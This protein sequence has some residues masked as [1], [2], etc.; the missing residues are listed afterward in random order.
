MGSVTEL[1]LACAGAVLGLGAWFLTWGVL[2]RRLLWIPGGWEPTT[3]HLRRLSVAAVAGLIVLV[4]TG[5]I[6]AAALV[7]LGLVIFEGRLGTRSEMR[8]LTARGEAVAS[9]TEMVYS[10]IAAGGGIERAIIASARNAPRSIRDEVVR[11]AARLEVR[12]LPEAMR[13]FTAE[14]AHPAADKVAVALVLASTHGA[15]DLVSLLRTQVDSTRREI[16]MHLE[17]E[18]GRARYRTSARI[19]VGVTAL[20][21]VGLYLADRGYLEPY[22]TAIGQMV[23][24]CVG[25]VFMLGFWLLIRMADTREPDRY[26]ASV[27]E[28]AGVR[29]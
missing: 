26:F 28:P 12:P 16:K 20:M 24:I 21:A 29:P 2:G 14:I 11:L 1:L 19:I 23:L 27:A 25:A 5:W 6:A 3:I 8:Q 9:W 13:D 7:A 10:A 22:D 15:H 17:V 4:A 18:A